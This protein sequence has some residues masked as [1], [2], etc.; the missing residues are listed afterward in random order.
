MTERRLYP[1]TAPDGKGSGRLSPSLLDRLIDLDPDL[2]ADPH[3]TLAETAT[4]L[5]AA[6]RRDLELL[7]NTRCRPETPPAELAELR[8]SLMSF[9]IE[10]FFATSLVTKSQRDAFARRIQ[11]VIA[12]FEPRLED[13]S[14]TLISDPVPERRSLRLRISARYAARPGLP[15]VVFETAM[16]PV[17]GR[18]TVSDQRQA[19]VRNG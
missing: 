1:W 6:L 15:P 8:Q 13:L 19:E 11:A 7:L 14:V 3:V 2:E 9:G 10:D 4:G 5:R 17:A 12:L 16:D 18:F